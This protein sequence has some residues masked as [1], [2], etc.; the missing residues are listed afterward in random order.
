MVDGKQ[1]APQSGCLS[2]PM[3][4][5]RPSSWKTPAIFRSPSRTLS[6]ESLYRSCRCNKNL[7]GKQSHCNDRLKMTPAL[8]KAL[9]KIS[10]QTCS[11]FDTCLPSATDAPQTSLTDCHRD[12]DLVHSAAVVQPVLHTW[13]RVCRSC[14]FESASWHHDRQG[15]PVLQ[16]CCN[17][18]AEP[19]KKSHLRSNNCQHLKS[20][21]FAHCAD[22]LIFGS[23]FGEISSLKSL[24][25][26]FWLN[27][28]SSPSQ[29]ASGN[30]AHC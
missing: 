16:M 5:A 2:C 28:L 30:Q 23:D 4:P 27:L 13:R 19:K 26:V 25:L 20:K 9:K 18:E 22:E 3:D 24:G 7:P 15:S 10:A 21:M 8:W 14:P 29:G 12:Y 6:P 17:F 1:L 11:S